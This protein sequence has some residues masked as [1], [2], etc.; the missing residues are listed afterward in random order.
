VDYEWCLSYVDRRAKDPVVVGRK[1]TPLLPKY[2]DQGQLVKPGRFVRPTTIRKELSITL[3]PALV[4]ARRLGRYSRDPDLV[5]PDLDDDYEPRK[6]W[7]LPW[8]LVGLALV[9]KLSQMAQI[10][11]GAALGCDLC[12]IPRARREDVRRDL[13]GARVRGTKRDTRDRFVPTPLPEQQALLRFALENGDGKDGLLFQPWPSLDQAL[14]KACRA[15]DIE[16]ASANDLRR[17][18]STW[19]RRAGVRVDLIAVAMGH[20]D[21]R[22]LGADEAIMVQ[23]VYGRLDGDD[24]VLFALMRQQIEQ[25][26]EA[27]AH[28]P[29][30][31]GFLPEGLG[32]FRL[33]N[34]Q[35]KPE[36]GDK[37]SNL[38]KRSQNPLSC[39]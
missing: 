5:I 11:Y 31:G 7:F 20:K 2:D 9:L 29:S 4:H 27:R 24:E 17:T 21:S 38:D 32:G 30:G 25:M 28:S 3:K 13:R 33:P 34:S 16:H 1:R 8:D 23:R 18:Y 36:L 37:D 6:R 39:R 19:L 35:R 26:A 12:A 14:A 15:L 10:A 22:Q